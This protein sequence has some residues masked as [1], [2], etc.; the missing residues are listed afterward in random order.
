MSPDSAHLLIAGTTEGSA[1]HSMSLC[2]DVLFS[3]VVLWDLRERPANFPS[4][5]IMGENT[6]TLQAPSYNTGSMI[7]LSSMGSYLDRWR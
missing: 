6:F 3:A 4:K 1:S 7:G 5:Y 2:A